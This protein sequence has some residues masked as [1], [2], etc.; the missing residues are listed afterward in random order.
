MTFVGYGHAAPRTNAGKAFCVFYATLGIPLTLVM[1]QSLG[2]R[3]NTL[4]RCLLRRTKQSLG[5]QNVEVSMGNMVVVGLLSCASALCV[6]AAAFSHFEDWSFFNAYY[7]CFTTLTTI[8]FGDFVALQKT[9]ALQRQP[10]YVAFTLMYILVGLTIMGAFINLVVLRF[11]A[12]SSD[13]LGKREVADGEEQVPKPKDPQEDRDVL[14][15]E[16]ETAAAANTHRDDGNSIHHNL[17]L[18]M[19]TGT[20]CINLLPPSEGGPRHFPSSHGDFTLPDRN[21]LTP[22]LFCFCCGLGC[23]DSSSLS[24]SD[25][26]P[27][28]SNLI[29]YNSISYKVDQASIA[30]SANRGLCHCKNSCRSR[31][32]SL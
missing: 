16:G 23:D 11:L 18:P 10:T 26:D 28:H 9:D 20:S 21:K 1:F 4:V 25:Q 2:E 12:V 6:G 13:R 29:F 19:E 24:G 14:D 7:Y 8:G 27:G 5:L 30:A 22:L 32:R 31:S 3:I 17:S 15:G